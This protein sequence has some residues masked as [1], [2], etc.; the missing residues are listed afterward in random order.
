[1]RTASWVRA[2]PPIALL[3]AVAFYACSRAAADTPVLDASSATLHLEEHLGAAQVTGS[4]L[5]ADP[6]QS[7]EWRFSEAQPGWKPAPSFNPSIANATITATGEV[8]RVAMSDRTRN[9]NG[10]PV[11]GIYVDVPEWNPNDLGDVIVRVRSD[12][13]IT[14]MQLAYNLRSGQ[15]TTGVAPFAFQRSVQ[16]LPLVRDGTIQTYRFRANVPTSQEQG[17]IRQ[18][19]LWF[20]SDGNPGSVD[21]LSVTVSAPG[22]AYRSERYATRQ[23]TKAGRIRR[24]TYVHAPA[25]LSYRV[26]VPESGRLDL[27][28][29]VLRADVPVTFRVS[30]Q[31]GRSDPQTLFEEAYSDPEGWAQRSI[32]LDTLAGRTVLLSLEAEAATPGTVALWSAPTLSGA[33][34]ADKP[35]VIFYVIDGGG[36]DQMSLYGYNR[37]TTPNLEAL[38]REGAVFEHVHATAS[39]TR[40][41]TTTFMTSLHNRVLGGISTNF[42]PLPVEARTMAERFHEAGYGT[43]VFTT[44]PNAGS[45]SALERGVDVFRDFDVADAVQSSRQLHGEFWDWREAFPGDP[46]WVHFQTTDVHWPNLAQAPFVGLFGP[47]DLK[48]QRAHWDT[49]LNR[50]ATQNRAR[51]R[52]NENA[53]TQQWAESGVDRVQYNDV[54]RVLY[55][56]TMAQQDHELGRFIE[57][58]KASGEWDRTLLIIAADHGISAGTGDFVV[59]LT[60]APDSTTKWVM[61]RS[62]ISRV[63]LMFVWPGHIPG[64]QRFQQ[65]VSMIDV[66]PTVLELA[67]LPL[68]DVLQGQSLVPLMLGREGW[69]PRPVI[70]DEFNKNLRTSEL[71]GQIE[72][73]DGRWGASLQIRAP[74]DTTPQRRPEFLLFDVWNDPLALKPLNEEHP[75]LV[76]KYTDL[77]RKQLAAHELLATRFTPGAKVEL[78]PEQLQTLRALGYIR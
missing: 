29:G 67:G 63:P 19:G 35:N 12:N 55:D 51:T 75:D 70:L 58:L 38:A 26:R 48:K 59:P 23:V 10:I 31:Q 8:L 33:R 32:E 46:Y 3:C 56:E 76:E 44:N 78:T 21:V 27:G 68:P 22:E 43:A 5:P 9:L 65:P 11:G 74:S 34:V 4:E 54:R 60:G 36:A 71:Q 30:A 1:M 17:P 13:S 72:M 2:A 61:F 6:P 62:S 52:A 45:I 37:R 16:G 41:S 50:W 14:N 49:L 69:Q 53:W 24:A 40:P 77:L 28:L 18:L 64:G 15:R 47:P 39:W 25:R 20:F 57:R 7:T 66:L 73:I 42:E